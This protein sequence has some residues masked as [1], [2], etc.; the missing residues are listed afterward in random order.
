MVLKFHGIIRIKA[1]QAVYIRSYL[2]KLFFA[3]NS[4]KPN[5][6]NYTRR[7]WLIF[8]TFLISQEEVSNIFFDLF[9]GTLR[10]PEC[11]EPCKHLKFSS[12]HVRSEQGVNKTRL[13][14]NFPNTVIIHEEQMDVN[15]FSFFVRWAEYVTYIYIYIYT[16]FRSAM[17][18]WNCLLFT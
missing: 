15:I 13:Y 18:Y 1:L 9:A 5:R 17:I 11:L 10:T 7:D 3:P 8:K 16:L 6:G 4:T 14:I 2:E 12:R